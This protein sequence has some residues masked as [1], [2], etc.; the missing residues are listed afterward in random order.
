MNSR[1]KAIAAGDPHYI[2]MICKKH[3]EL[4]GERRTDSGA[5]E[6]CNREAAKRRGRENSAAFKAAKAARAAKAAKRRGREL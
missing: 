6:P 4:W 3:P 2:G 5:C 1:K